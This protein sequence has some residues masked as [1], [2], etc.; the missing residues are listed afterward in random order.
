M[1]KHNPKLEQPNGK[2]KKASSQKGVDSYKEHKSYQKIYMTMIFIGVIAVITII[3]FFIFGDQGLRVEKYDLV[4]LDYK[5]YTH[6]DYE[7]NKDPTINKKKVWLNVSSRYDDKSEDDIIVGFYKELLGKKIGDTL[8][9]KLI[10]KCRD[11]DKDEKDDTSGEDALSYGFPS[12]DLYNTDIVLWFH[13]LDINK[14]GPE[15]GVEI[16]SA[17]IS[18]D[19]NKRDVNIFIII[20]INNRKIREI[21]PVYPYS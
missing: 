21:F 9:N 19:F 3:F 1:P 8:P 4:K 14:S 18:S 12:D 17:Q 10:E 6:D 11:K 15:D 7:N 16:S 2:D 20:I 5:I 13:I